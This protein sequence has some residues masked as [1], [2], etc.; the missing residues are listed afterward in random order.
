MPGTVLHDERT[1]S[2][3]EAVAADDALVN[4]ARS[5][6]YGFLAAVFLGRTQELHSAAWP[7][8]VASIEA[9]CA[10]VGEPPPEA[11]PTPE[12]PPEAVATEFARL[13]YGIGET[14]IPMAGS[15]YA[16]D[17]RLH[18]QQPYHDARAFY[19]RHGVARSETLGLPDDH[20]AI[21][22]AF[23]HELAGT[24]AAVDTQREFVER[25]LA[26]WIPRFCGEIEKSSRLGSLRLLA[27]ALH[28][29]VE[30]DRHWLQCDLADR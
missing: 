30:A 20:V 10:V 21:E 22:L 8:V 14:T 27:Q 12:D 15:C 17:L 26:P 2:A 28:K 13:F 7:Q 29:L 11:R 9:F 16:N 1:V 5:R 24:P 25:H 18:C 4:L 3:C 19:A 6:C 23:M